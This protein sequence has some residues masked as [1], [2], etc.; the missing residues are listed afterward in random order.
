M[1]KK[2]TQP[3]VKLIDL[4]GQNDCL[5]AASQRLNSQSENILKPLYYDDDEYDED[6][7]DWGD[8]WGN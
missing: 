2:Y 4:N 5:L 6:Y 1:K 7:E 3:L 8:N